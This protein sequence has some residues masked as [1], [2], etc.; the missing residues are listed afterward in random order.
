MRRAAKRD[1]SE[2]AIVKALEQAGVSVWRMDQPVDLLLGYRGKT[3][4]AECKTGKRKL[5]A[6]QARF[7]DEWRGSAVIVLRTVDDAIE[8]VNGFTGR[9][10]Q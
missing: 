3:V 9:E 1:L 2:P 6:N 10:S 4:L 5:N 8:F 7:V